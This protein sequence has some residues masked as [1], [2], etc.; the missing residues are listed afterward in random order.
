[1]LTQELANVS[2]LYFVR[3]FY[4]SVDIER[5]YQTALDTRK[6]DQ[7]NI[8]SCNFSHFDLIEV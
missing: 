6:L 2:H 3:L 8:F 1:M 4:L 7:S 5:L